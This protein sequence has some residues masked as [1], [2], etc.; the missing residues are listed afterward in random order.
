M[1]G[2]ARTGRRGNSVRGQSGEEFRVFSGLLQGCV[3]LRE[4]IGGPS[5]SEIGPMRVAHFALTAFVVT[6]LAAGCST[7]GLTVR[8]STREPHGASGYTVVTAAELARIGRQGSLMDA[9]ERLRPSMLASRGATPLVSVD[10]SPASDLSSLRMIGA[11]DVREVRLHRAS[12]SVGRSA[13]LRNGD[14]VVGDLIVV[15]TW[16]G[17]GA[18]PGRR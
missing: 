15:T 6:G 8:S 11:S 18:R 9:L 12:S 2:T 4:Q 13:V 10:G 1:A 5:F 7:R 16:R 14:V 3:T 17:G